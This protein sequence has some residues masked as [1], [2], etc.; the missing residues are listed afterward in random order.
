MC[1]AK[2]I[3]TISE[4]SGQ[5]LVKKRIDFLPDRFGGLVFYIDKI[6]NI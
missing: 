2:C 5:F 6:I 4:Y 1:L 3:N